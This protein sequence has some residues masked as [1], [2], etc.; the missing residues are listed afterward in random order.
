MSL[1]AL[2][3]LAQDAEKKEEAPKVA[4]P[5]PA[6]GVQIIQ[7][8]AIPGPAI[9]PA[10]PAAPAN[11]AAAKAE[12]QKKEVIDEELE[13]EIAE[14][15]GE[16]EKL[17][18]GTTD[19]DL[20][21]AELGRKER[22][23]A[24]KVAQK[25]R[26]QAIEEQMSSLLTGATLDS[27]PEIDR[28]LDRA[29]EYAAEGR[30]RDASTLWQHVLDQRTGLT[31]RLPMTKD[32]QVTPRTG[33]QILYRPVRELIEAEI[34]ALPA[35]GLHEYRIV[36]DAE[37]RAILAQVNPDNE[38]DQLAKVVRQYFISSLGDDAA[39]RLACMHMDEWDFVAARRLLEKTTRMHPDPSIARSDLL[40]RL[41]L[42]CAKAGDSQAARLA[43]DELQ[44]LAA[45]EVVPDSLVAAVKEA[46]E[47]GAPLAVASEII[48]GWPMPMGTAGRDGLM[49]GLP[50]KPVEKNRLWTEQPVYQYEYR[51]PEL[52]GKEQMMG[53]P[54]QQNQ[55]RNEIVS[56]WEKGGWTPNAQVALS[57]ALPPTQT[58]NE[59]RWYEPRPRQRV[60]RIE[61]KKVQIEN[62][63]RVWVQNVYYGNQQKPDTPTSQEEIA[64]F[65]DRTGKC[66]A[67]IDDT[68]YHIEGKLYTGMGP[69]QRVMMWNN[70]RQSSLEL[71]ESLVAVDVTDK[72]RGKRVKWRFPKD[73]EA[74]GDVRFLAAP[75]P[76]GERLLVPAIINQELMLLGLKKD[77]GEVAFKTSLCTPE[78]S[79]VNRWASV[80][81]AVVGSEAYVASGFGV[82]FSVDAGTGDVL[83]AVRYQRSEPDSEGTH[84]N[85]IIASRRRM[86]NLPGFDED[87][88]IPRGD[89]LLLA[90]SDSDQVQC[91]SR[92]TGQLL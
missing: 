68:L 71:V 31:D 33:S 58:P 70:G 2:V 50:G 62:G 36:A 56:R 52:V 69:G 45:R 89:K 63:A 79:E 61:Q 41:A 77:T 26:E 85:I 8:Q 35:E 5:V 34:A 83:W 19:Y 14:L 67:L 23:L 4:K 15:K 75:T 47:N 11:A 42:A 16:L 76:V 64:M 46:V 6:D 78:A 86:Q 65:G 24:A 13:K 59:P 29:R 3:A 18:K 90:A 48:E 54:Q 40:I 57:G 84:G 81:I 60:D 28:L 10:K 44:K 12:E 49:G 87:V 25:R 72:A 38:V 51:V 55:S 21:A 1:T 30:Y 22:L 66:M 82:V 20:K 7:L 53:T 92:A 32:G 27:D 39:Y 43:L 80:G 17:K 37:A 73:D 91:L 9:V 74:G 88:I